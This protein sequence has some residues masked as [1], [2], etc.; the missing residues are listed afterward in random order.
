MKE[1][2][3]L[4][5]FLTVFLL[6]LFGQ[7]EI[8]CF[9]KKGKTVKNYFPGSYIAFL[10]MNPH[11]QYGIIKRIRKD[12]IYLRPYSIQFSLTGIDTFSYAG[13]SF[14]SLIF[15]LSPNLVWK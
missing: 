15:M 7:H 13:S 10:D 11:W 12:S 4:S 6:H 14:S 3:L 9:Q 1:K 5:G 8:L 2:S